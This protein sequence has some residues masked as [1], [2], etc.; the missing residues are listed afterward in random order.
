MWRVRGGWVSRIGKMNWPRLQSGCARSC[1]ASPSWMSRWWSMSAP[2]LTGTRRTDA[3]Q[4]PGPLLQ[5]AEYFPDDAGARGERILANPL[6]LLGHHQ[7][8]AVE[9]LLCHVLV[10]VRLLFPDEAEGCA[11]FGV[12]VVALRQAN[13]LGRLLNDRQKAAVQLILGGPLEVFGARSLAAGED[14][15][16]VLHRHLAHRVDEQLPRLG[17]CGLGGAIH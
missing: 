16:G 5:S 2:A 13:F 14:A 15:L 8:E 12:V 6:L 4:G 10:E 17:N 11:L 3:P 9:R 1:K 7:I